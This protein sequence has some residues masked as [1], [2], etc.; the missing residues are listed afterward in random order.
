MRSSVYIKVGPCFCLSKLSVAAAAR[1]LLWVQPA[2]D[3]D[4]L[5]HGRRRSS[6]AFSS[7][8]GQCHVVSW[9]RKLKTG[10]LTLP[11]QWSAERPSL[12]V[13]LSHR[14]TAAAVCGGFAAE[15]RAGKYIDRQQRRSAAMAPQQMR[16]V[17]CWQP[18]DEAGHLF[19]CGPVM[20]KHD[21]IHKTEY[22]SHI[23]RVKWRHEIYGHDAIAILWV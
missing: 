13:R 17:S 15:R 4:R 22:S 2:S 5:L 19:L 7:K 11:G 1:L 20:R 8:C 21:V 3:I 23:H 14:S 6:T 16:A 9:R 10:L 18:R 12:C